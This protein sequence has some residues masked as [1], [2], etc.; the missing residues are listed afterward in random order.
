MAA[1]MAIPFSQAQG[2][3]LSGT[4]PVEVMDESPQPKV[5]PLYAND[6]NTLGD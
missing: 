2:T 5:L 1:F 4:T 3:I 6:C